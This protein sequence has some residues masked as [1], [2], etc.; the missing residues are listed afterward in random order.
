MTLEQ[1]VRIPRALPIVFGAMVLAFLVL[2]GGL[3][4]DPLQDLIRPAFLPLMAITFALG[5][6]LLVLSIR[7]R[8]PST[9]RTLWI[10]AG[11]GPVGF[12]VGSVLHNAFYAVETVTGQWAIL[13]G[14]A[15]VLGV[16]FF[17]IAVL[18][19]PIAFVV[20]TIGAIVALVLRRRTSAAGAG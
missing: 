8:A 12:V 3:Q 17:L 4:Y 6:A 13:H 5:V 10:V 16:A 15:Q 2:A 9:L 1:K 20:G 14:A 19:C 18:V 11:A 7:W